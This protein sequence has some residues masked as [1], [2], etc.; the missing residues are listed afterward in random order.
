MTGQGEGRRQHPRYNVT[1]FVDYTGSIRFTERVQNISLGGICIHTPHVEKPGTVVELRVR[2]PD[3]DATFS[4]RG[5]VVWVN[6]RELMDTGIKFLD[7]DAEHQGMLQRY[8]EA[9]QHKK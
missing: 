1:A 3:L 8:L 5:E 6:D 9:V 4:A 2:F 7:L